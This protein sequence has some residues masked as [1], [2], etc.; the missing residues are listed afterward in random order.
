M[1]YPPLLLRSRFGRP[2]LSIASASILML[3]G[4]DQN[5]PSA[6]L[7]PPSSANLSKYVTGQAAQSLN[8][9]G[10]FEIPGPPAAPDAPIISKE[11]AGDLAVAF[12][13][14]WGRFYVKDWMRQHGASINL[15]G[16]QVDPRIHYVDSPYG[17]F[18]DGYHPA[19]RRAY[20]PWYLVHLTAGAT[21][22]L[23]VAVSAYN[24][25]LEIDPVGKLVAQRLSGNDFEAMAISRGRAGFK[26]VSPEVA[27][28]QVGQRSGARITRAPE[29]ALLFVNQHPTNAA[30]AVWKLSMDRPLRVRSSNGTRRAEVWD[31]FVGSGGAL[32][33]P[34]STQPAKIEATA[35]RY[36]AHGNRVG[37]ETV[38][39]QVKPG[40]AVSFEEVVLEEGP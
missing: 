1:R 30:A 23:I 4:C 28:S 9:R 18:P 3:A 31:V 20:G 33:I 39:V 14:T 10:E 21:P 35:I 8:A 2:A 25:D 16:L 5:E 19:F 6:T 34:A 26:P 11:R 37:P 27:V 17:H 40:A 29:L 32:H 13:R 15:E 7:L 24:T 38:N 36:D 22:V 12:V